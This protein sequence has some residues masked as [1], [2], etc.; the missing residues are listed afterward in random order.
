MKK[1][2]GK[3]GLQ[4]VVVVVDVLGCVCRAALS[5]KENAT[6]SCTPAFGRD[7]GRDTYQV[8]CDGMEGGWDVIT[9]TTY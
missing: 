1:G 2:R 3:K 8:G 4:R 7:G 9:A 6:L 5:E